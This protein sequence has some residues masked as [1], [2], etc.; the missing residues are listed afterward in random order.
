M[1][2]PT[3]SHRAA[4]QHPIITCDCGRISKPGFFLSPPEEHTSTC[5]YH[6]RSLLLSRHSLPPGYYAALA[7]KISRSR[8]HTR[9]VVL[10]LGNPSREMFELVAAACGLSLDE[11]K[12]VQEE[13]VAR[14]AAG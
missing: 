13:R 2:T 8:H 10:G 3:P 6:L 12:R 5:A 7:R 9:R 11:L 1:H 14:L 4:Q